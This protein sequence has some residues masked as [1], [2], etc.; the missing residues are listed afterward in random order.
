[1]KPRFIALSAM[2][3]TIGFFL[4]RWPE[5]PLSIADSQQSG[6]RV[7][8]AEELVGNEETRDI[9]AARIDK[10]GVL[11]PRAQLA[12]LLKASIGCGM[13][14]DD[15]NSGCIDR[16]AA[17]VPMSA[18]ER[19]QLRKHLEN[20]AKERR[21][22]E[23]ANVRVRTTRAGEWDLFFPGDGGE[24]R[25]NLR[26]GIEAI[27]GPERTRQIDLLGDIDG[28]FGMSWLAPSF[29][30]GTVR[31]RTRVGTRLDS[32]F[33]RH[34]A[35]YLS[36]AFGDRPAFEYSMDGT[37]LNEQVLRERI[38][39]LLGGKEP[40]ERAALEGAAGK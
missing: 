7:G 22:W 25:R 1:M 18:T 24:A 2:G 38:L 29:L 21:D 16:L 39:P 27:F 8:K 17:L 26:Q 32:Q 13:A 12:S 31:V 15:A 23:Q 20:A 34:E 5:V 37:S 35:V 40:V 9:R 10:N 11:I 33:R 36:L 3:A 19:E 30:H 14:M 6:R 28:Y 4:A